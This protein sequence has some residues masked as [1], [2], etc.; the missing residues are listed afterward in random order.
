[1]VKLNFIPSVCTFI[2]KQTSFSPLL[3]ICEAGTT[4]LKIVR[5]EQIAI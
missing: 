3:A 1:M 2:E 4:V 5:A